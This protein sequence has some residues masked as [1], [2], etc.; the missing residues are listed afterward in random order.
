V[1]VIRPLKPSDLPQVANLFELV[2]RSG[3]REAP[4]GLV[5]YFERTVLGHPW[6]DPELPSLIYERE[7]RVLGF[8]ASHA[9][10]ARLDGNPLR[11]AAGGQ[12]V[13]DPDARNEAAGFFLLRAFMEGAQDITFTDT[14]GVATQRMW[15]RL[16]GKTSLLRSISWFHLFRP[17]RFAQLLSSAWLGKTARQRAD[18]SI[19]GMLDSRAALHRPVRA[20]AGDDSEVMSEGL[21]AEA[22]VEL[23]PTLRERLRLY[24]DY[25]AS[26]ARWLLESATSVKHHGTLVARLVRRRNGKPLGW[27]VY[28]LDPGGISEVLQVVAAEHDVSLVLRHLFR[29]AHEHRSAILRGRVEPG[30][31]ESLSQLRCI[32]RYSGAAL[33]HARDPDVLAVATS[34]D[35]LLTRLDGEWWMGHSVDSFRSVEPTV[36]AERERAADPASR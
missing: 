33:I 14:A 11:M 22:L 19:V 24:P 36:A 2:G 23:F 31:L 10:R 30:L 17:I 28:Y 26:F 18:V 29:H 12:L 20:L 9:R 13:A 8:I 5:P 16:G 7:G 35:S 21:T 6:A 4:P 1:S 15:K 32:F 25:D 27:Y 34:G 3:S